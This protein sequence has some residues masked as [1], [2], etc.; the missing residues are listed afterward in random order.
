MIYETM[1]TDTRNQCGGCCR[2]AVVRVE[3][4]ATPLCPFVPSIA[5]SAVRKPGSIHLHLFTQMLG[6][7]LAEHLSD[8]WVRLHLLITCRRAP[9]CCDAVETEGSVFAATLNG[10]HMVY[11]PLRALEEVCSL[12]HFSLA[13]VVCRAVRAADDHAVVETRYVVDHGELRIR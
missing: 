11:A 12:H 4:L 3:V 10:D 9:F 6:Y 7:Q 2:T 13:F 5:R 1:V 8:A